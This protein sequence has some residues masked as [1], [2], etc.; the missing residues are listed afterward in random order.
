MARYKIN[1]IEYP[2]VTEILGLLDKSPALMQWAVN[3]ALEY[4]KL[5]GLTPE[6]LIEAKSHYRDVSAEM[7]DIGSEVH[8]SIEAYIKNGKDKMGEIKPEVQN[9]LIAFWDWEKEHKVKWLESEMAVV[10][11]RVGIAGTLDAIAEVSGIVTCIDFKSSKAIYPE[12]KTQVI[13]YKFARESMSGRYTIKGPSGD[14]TQ[15]YGNIAIKNCAILRLDKQTGL[16]E[17]C[18]IDEKTYDREFK[19]F[20]NLVNYYYM[21]KQRKL[22]N[23]ER[24]LTNKGL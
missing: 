4:V 5:H 9:A 7:M 14:Y 13:V 21:A 22:K 15:N 17:Y 11:E 3:Q 1:D 8:S 23:N 2:S 24:V 18:E 12:Y 6:S 20:I 16:P 19:A 10:D